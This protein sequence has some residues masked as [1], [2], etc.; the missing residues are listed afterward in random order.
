[1]QY[2][3]KELVDG[4]KSQIIVNPKKAQNALL[5]IYK[6]QTES[7]QE[8]GYTSINNGVGFSGVDSEFLSSLAENLIRYK[9]LSDKQNNYL[10]KI[11]PKYASQLIRLS[12][13]KGLIVK[14][15]RKYEIHKPTIEV[16]EQTEMSF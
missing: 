6:Y 10:M 2:S 4:L 15:G 14:V 5:E 16:V 3:K 11:M 13:S 9:R 12:I 8:Q 1:M 7:E